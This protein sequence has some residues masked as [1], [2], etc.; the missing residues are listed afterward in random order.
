MKGGVSYENYNLNN[1]FFI[2]GYKLSDDS[3][4]KIYMMDSVGRHRMNNEKYYEFMDLIM[5][6]YDITDR[7]SFQDCIDYF[8]LQIKERC[9]D[10]VKVILLGNKADLEDKREVPLEEAEEFAFLNN[11]LFM[12]I[13]CQTNKNIKEAFETI[14]EINKSGQNASNKKN[15]NKLLKY[16]NY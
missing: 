11:Y 1:S 10:N 8:S 9:N 14:F 7:H 4:L 13:S 15:V 16:I 3:I 2:F 12:E 6:L 5:L